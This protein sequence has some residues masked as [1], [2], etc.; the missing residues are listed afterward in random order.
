MQLFLLI[1]ALP[2]ALHGMAPEGGVNVGDRAP[3]FAANTE[4]GELWRL[5]D[6]VGKKNIVVF[7]YPAAMTGGCTAQACSFRD[8]SAAL[9]AADAVVV[10][11]SGDSVNALEVF[12]M[13]HDLNF[14]LLSDANGS[15]ANAYGVPMRDGGSL[16]REVDGKTYTLDRGVTTMRWTFIIGMDGKIVYKNDQVKAG[17]DGAVVLAELEKLAANS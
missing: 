17:E 13:A 7:F 16:E 12:K 8:R 10:G 15:I 11:V 14:S 6:H 9:N 1:L 2:F 4:S 3:D 5:S